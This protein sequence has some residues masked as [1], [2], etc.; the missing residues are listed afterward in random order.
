MAKVLENAAALGSGAVPPELSEPGA[1]G[2]ELR[3]ALGPILYDINV[4]QFAP[5]GLNFGYFYEHSPIIVTDH[6]TPPD[7]TMGTITPSTVPG[8]RLPHFVVDGTPILDLLGPDYTLIRFDAAVDVD[9]LVNAAAT[10]GLPLIVLDVPRPVDA[11]VFPTDLVI[12]RYDQ[13]V[14]WRANAAP[15]D[16][17]ELVATFRGARTAVRIGTV[18]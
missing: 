8:C 16:C 5:E 18:R 2:D 3:A 14:A 1:T 11:E 10:A 12:V 13:H 7:Y 17:D 9:P 4:A 6:E 15:D